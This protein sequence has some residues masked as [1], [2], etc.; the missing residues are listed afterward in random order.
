[1]TFGIPFGHT[2]AVLTLAYAG[3]ALHESGRRRLFAGA[4]AASA[5]AGVL[6]SVDR[7]AIFGMAIGLLLL[8]RMRNN[9][10]RAVPSSKRPKTAVAWVA[11]A[12]VALIIPAASL[13]DSK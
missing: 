5:A 6:L 11:A 13:P 4:G 2:M 7:T 9:S 8:A 1:M 3:L 10:D 12:A